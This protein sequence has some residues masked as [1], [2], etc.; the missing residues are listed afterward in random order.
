ML[1]PHD[2]DAL[3]DLFDSIVKDTEARSFFH[4]HSFDRTTALD[5]CANVNKRQD[6]FFVAFETP[7][8]VGY[9]M[10]RGWDEGY[11]VP[12]FG[13]YVAQDRRDEGIGTALLDYAIEVAR[14]KGCLEIMLKVYGSNRTAKALYE[15]RGF[16]FIDCAS[17]GHQLIG[18][19]RLA[20]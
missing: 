18:R 9:G 4:P 15:S 3:A 11:D 7:R 17:D 1:C 10:L 5:I 19:L 8:I 2:G 16:L 20:E 13:V 14:M 6:L 12:S